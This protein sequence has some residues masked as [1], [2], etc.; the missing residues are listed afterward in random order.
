[1]IDNLVT[2]AGAGMFSCSGPVRG[3]FSAVLGLFPG[4]EFMHACNLDAPPPQWG[5]PGYLLRSDRADAAAR[6]VPVRRK[7]AADLCGF[8]G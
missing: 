1:M 6:L 8:Y 3:F 2:A 4:F 5:L 7:D